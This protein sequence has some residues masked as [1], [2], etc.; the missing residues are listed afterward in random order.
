MASPSF[1]W[2][3][4]H[5]DTVSALRNL[6]TLAWL[7]QAGTALDSSA[8]SLASHASIADLLWNYWT[9]EHLNLKKLMMNLATREASF[10]RSFALTDLDSAD[11]DALTPW[12]DKLPLRLNQRTNHVE[13][14]HDLAADWSRF[15]FLKQIWPDTAHWATFAQ[16]P[17]WT[18]ALR[19]L[20]QYLLRQTTE[21]GT[22]WDSA[23]DSAEGAGLS[24]AGDILLDALCLD[25]VTEQFLTER[26]D[27]L[28]AND[29][30]HLTKLLIRFHHVGTVPI[31]GIKSSAASLALYMEAQYR[32]V[33]IG[34]WPPVLRFLISQ[35]EKLKD[36]ISPALAKVIQ[37]WLTRTPLEFGDGTQVPFRQELAE[38]ALNIA[39]TV[40]VEKGK[41]VIFSD[42]DLLLYTAPL[43]GVM[44][45]P[46]KIGAWAL[47]LAGRREMATEVS[48]RIAQARHQQIE[49][50][51]ERL[52]SD[53]KYKAR[54]EERCKIPT[55]LGAFR[56]ELPPWPLGASCKVD[57][58][59]R[60]ACFKGNGLQPLMRA[61]PDIASEVLLALIVE[62]QPE[63]DYNS[64][65][66]EV[67]LGLDFARD[68]YPTA[69]WKSPFFSFLQIA[70]DAALKALIA[71][72]N[73][74]TERWIAEIMGGRDEPAP[75]LKLLMS[76]SEE[77]NFAGG[78]EVFDW[79]QTNSLHNGNLFCALDAL[80]RWLT[81]QIDNGV[82]IT[83]HV[84]Q[85]VREGNS[86][87]LIGT[88]VNV[89]KYRP[90]LFSGALAPL[91]TDPHVFYWDSGRVKKI[92]L[93]FDSLNWIRA[94]EAVFNIARD[95]TLAPHR[96]KSL[97]DVV[98]G[99]LKVDTVVSE[100]LQALIPNWSLPKDQREPWSSSCS[101][102]C[103]TATTIGTS[104]TTMRVNRLRLLYVLMTS[105]L[106]PNRGRT[107][108]L[109]HCNTYWYPNAAR[110][111]CGRS[112][113]WAMMTR[114]IC[115]IS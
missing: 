85:I 28:M 46:E 19:M 99:L 109:N 35:R 43:A 105:A 68:G 12:P 16:N 108:A 59:F 87:A 8:S 17:L 4:G 94:G 62:D 54:Y 13:F 57:M 7:L 93:N 77:K 22:A 1:G 48:V 60:E 83:P 65:Q 86:V 6:K 101:L 97:Q 67:E 96:Q 66:H 47:E 49:Q 92:V 23:F 37:T 40:Q 33:V 110:T 14:E 73:F 31:G 36:L 88:L 53:P 102:Q 56:E 55:S 30:R 20:G 104:T 9:G 89:G 79:T 42:C 21:H 84:E 80:E 91:L 112:K 10:E 90:N 106:K 115:T 82:D 15:Q 107:S 98:V 64:S 44:D 38:M 71:L 72:V 25:P 58:D 69:Y 51:N 76:E 70:P 63:R 74:C 18:N 34:R 111:F 114:S 103:S 45:L 61:R 27:L 75:G 78:W 100:R 29:A 5:E 81:L 113:L 95:W 26:V 24:L 41:G 2:L 39:R 11:A 3:T 52:R 50:H 32:S